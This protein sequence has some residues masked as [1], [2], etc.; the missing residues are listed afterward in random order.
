MNAIAQPIF[1]A[2]G[3]L[4]KLK[5]IDLSHVRASCLT[6]GHYSAEEIDQV[7]EEYK[8]YIA[9]AVSRGQGGLPISRRLDAFWHTHI[10]YTQSYMSMCMH[11][12][13]RY[14]HHRPKSLDDESVLHTRF[15]GE[16]IPLYRLNFGDPDTYFWDV[17]ECN[18]D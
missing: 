7:A 15:V 9:L 2:S 11:V 10:I 1:D 3:V 12:A 16:T 18:Y 13:G 14:I 17:A 8:K 6:H 4:L 5:D